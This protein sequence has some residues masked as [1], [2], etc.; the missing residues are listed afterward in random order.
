MIAPIPKSC[1]ADFSAVL[2]R[3]E[4]PMDFIKKD[5]PKLICGIEMSI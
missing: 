5:M 4:V 1:G 3:K 2:C